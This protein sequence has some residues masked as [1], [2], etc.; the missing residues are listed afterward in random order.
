MP[1]SLV[2]NDEGIPS[3]IKSQIIDHDPENTKFIWT[4][5]KAG[6]KISK[7][8]PDV[9][10]RSKSFTEDL[11]EEQRPRI[12]V[13]QTLEDN[14]DT[15]S[16][17]VLSF[18][19]NFIL[20]KDDYVL[21]VSFVFLENRLYTASQRE[22]SIFSKIMSKCIS[23]KI[24]FT[25]ISFFVFLI[26]EM[27]EM[28]INALENVEKLI[29][30]S[31]RKMLSGGLEKGWLA[32]LLQLKGRLYDASTSVRADI[33][34]IRELVSGKVP[35]LDI[36][37]IEDHIL[38][39]VLFLMDLIQEQREDLT[40][41]INLHLAIASNIMNRQFYWL[42]ILG[43]LLIIPTVISSIWGMNLDD[44]PQI[45]FWGMLL[46]ISI[47]TGVAGVILKL[48]LPKPMIN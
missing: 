34:H 48:L 26:S 46:V 47:M 36:E 29:D 25:P 27:L 20:K 17:I 31:E 35:N 18:P 19:T 2:F 32:N 4:N 28:S 41:M 10:D 12:Q 38:D 22:S 33:E 42:T 14:D 30:N 23:Q 16:V 37:K 24:N 39:R 9:V 8:L 15:Y 3:K 21:Q 43:A 7:V 5:L 13:Y 6:D 45:N 11:L 1:K 40:N 44:V